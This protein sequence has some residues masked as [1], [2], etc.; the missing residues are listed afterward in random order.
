MNRRFSSRQLTFLRN[1]VPISRV[2]EALP[3]LATRHADG[4][5]HF[6]CPLCH[7]FNTSV[8]VGPNLA[9][10]FDEKNFNPIEL[11]MHQLQI[12]FVESVKWLMQRTADK[13]AADSSGT[14]KSKSQPAPIGD[15]LAAMLAA[16]SGKKTYPLPAESIP[17]RVSNLEHHVRRLYHLVDEL[18]SSLDQK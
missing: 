12:S 18:R 7:G 8:N 5:L 6:G 16:P 11:V 17:Q 15:I 13:S 4:K 9:R 10:C 3:K 14:Y 1:Q 2:I